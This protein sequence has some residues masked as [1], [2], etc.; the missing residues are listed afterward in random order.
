MVRAVR[1]PA[2]SCIHPH[3]APHLP[4]HLP[5][6]RRPC[7]GRPDAALLG[8][9]RAGGPG[10]RAPQAPARRHHLGGQR[11]GPGSPSPPCA[12]AGA[13]LAS[14]RM[15]RGGGGMALSSESFISESH[16]SE[17]HISESHA[18][19]SQRYPLCTG[20]DCPLLP[21]VPR[22]SEPARP[23]GRGGATSPLRRRPGARGD[24]P[25][26]PPGPRRGRRALSE[27]GSRGSAGL[28]PCSELRVQ[29]GLP[30]LAALRAGPAAGD[31]GPH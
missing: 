8:L 4:E 13:R 23:A 14:V 28:N 20:R 30:S 27:S 5:E 25:G 11:G 16:I 18:S 15:V 29:G 7:A 31:A 26:R 22:C 10:R 1:M 19:E 12:R 17:S 2:I 6:S 3:C 24:R 9:G 21:P